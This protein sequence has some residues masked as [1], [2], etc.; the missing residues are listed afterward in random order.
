MTTASTVSDAPFR[1]RPSSTPPYDWERLVEVKNQPRS[2]SQ[3]QQYLEDLGGCGYRYFLSRVVR[4]W[5]RP[6]AWLPQGLAVHE[7]AEWWEKTNR[8]GS[9]AEIE[10][11]YRRAYNTHTQRLLAETPN[12]DFWFASGRYE[13]AEDI[14]R[15]ATI[16]LEQ[17]RAYY[18]YY[19]NQKPGELIWITPNG[20]PAIELEFNVK[21]GSVWV[22]GFIDQIIEQVFDESYDLESPKIMRDIKTGVKA[23][24]IF[25]LSVYR[26]AILEEF[27]VDILS[28]DFW[29]ARNGK[30]TK[31]LDLTAMTKEQV[32]DYFERLDAGVKAERFDPSPSA[33]K[34]SRCGVAT[35]CAFAE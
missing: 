34:C 18:D 33:E 2:V 24:N 6:A 21:F 30:P 17:T 12:P 32:T 14:I 23:G 9:L 19:V 22:K 13:G 11:V 3:A 26:H 27:G 8:K 31:P 28:G 1:E 15:R 4:A 7:A 29:M 20:S 25:Q 35:A 16:G 10:D 5:D